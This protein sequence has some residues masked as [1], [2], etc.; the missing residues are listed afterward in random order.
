MN[1]VLD[2][3][4]TTDDFSP[5]LASTECRYLR[6]VVYPDTLTAE[7]AVTRV[8]NSSFSMAYRLLSEAQQ[9]LVAEG[10]AVVV[11]VDPA[12]GRGASLSDAFRRR[13]AELQAT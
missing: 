8:G 5:I 12:T 11:N 4:V 10:T 13:V 1:A 3:Q 6:P 2:D 9:G 7:A